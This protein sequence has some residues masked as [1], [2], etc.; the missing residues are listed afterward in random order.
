M[1]TINIHRV[2][3]KET[4]SVFYITV[5]DSNASLWFLASNVVKVM[6][7]HRYSCCLPHLTI[8]NNVFLHQNIGTYQVQ[9][10]E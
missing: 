9:E 10:N 1:I 5:T 3:K 7:N 6:Q 4:S 8:S 2:G